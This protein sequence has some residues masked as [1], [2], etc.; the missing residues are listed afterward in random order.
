VVD[1]GGRRRLAHGRRFAGGGVI[2]EQRDPAFWREIASHPDLAGAL[3][4]ISP[5]QVQTIAARPDVLPLASDNGGYFFGRLDG[6]G[7][8]LELHSLF[9][10]A[11]WGREAAA[12]GKEALMSVFRTAQVITTYEVHGNPRSRPPRSYGFVRA[13]DWQTTRAG[14]LRLWVLTRAA[15]E[16]SPVFRRHKHHANSF[17]RGRDRGGRIDRRGADQQ[18]GDQQRSQ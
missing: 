8:V 16:S 1:V 15:W 6:L 2:R 10:P 9:R 12:T 11:G 7:L 4:E 17:D 3:M 14:T 5:E 13:G 18:F